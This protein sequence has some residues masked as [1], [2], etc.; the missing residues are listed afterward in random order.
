MIAGHAE[1]GHFAAILLFHINH[2][3]GDIDAIKLAERLRGSCLISPLLSFG[4]YKSNHQTR[5]KY[6]YLTL[7]H[8]Q[9]L[10]VNF[11]SVGLSDKEA[12]K[13]PYLLPFDAPQG[14]GENGAVHSILL[15][16]GT[17]SPRRCFSMIKLPSETVCRKQITQSRRLILYNLRKRHTQLALQTRYL[18]WNVTV[19][20][21]TGV[22][23]GFDF[24]SSGAIVS[25]TKK[26]E[27]GVV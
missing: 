19:Q 26:E 13:D 2:P 11:Q 14:W 21:N 10:L 25:L 7:K 5:A 16:V 9:D 24:L 17:W 27:V 4:Y 8:M 15:V 18:D 6:E 12:I 1:G 23:V 3:S 20:K 22:D